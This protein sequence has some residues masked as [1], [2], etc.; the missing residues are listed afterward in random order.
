MPMAIQGRSANF[1]KAEPGHGNRFDSTG[2]GRLI[3]STSDS[4]APSVHAA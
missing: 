3:A 2:K 1:I 4:F